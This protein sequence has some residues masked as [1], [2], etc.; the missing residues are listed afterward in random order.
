MFE[1]AFRAVAG[2]ARHWLQAGR[3]APASVAAVELDRFMGV[4]FEVARL[5]NLE[6]DGF[7]RRAVDVTATYGMRPDGTISVQTA[8]SNGARGRR[9]VVNGTARPVNPGGSRLL[10]TFYRVVRARLWIIGLDQEYRWALMGT[11]SGRRLWLIARQPRLA[12]ADYARAMAI[13]A[14]QGYDAARVRPT[15]QSR[16]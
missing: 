14:A 15:P 8:A 13:A 3:P 12:D 16:A 10:L 2:R 4:W 9:S 5:P 6:A 11:P 1:D 7:G